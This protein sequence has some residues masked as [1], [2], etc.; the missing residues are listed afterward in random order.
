MLEGS[1]GHIGWNV[2]LLIGAH[3]EGGMV[4]RPARP[5]ADMQFGGVLFAPG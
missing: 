5:L 2:I 3:R 1:L 4:G